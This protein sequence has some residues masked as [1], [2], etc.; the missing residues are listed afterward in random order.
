MIPVEGIKSF[1]VQTAY[2]LRQKER[3]TLLDTMLELGGPALVNKKL[4]QVIRAGLKHKSFY[5]NRRLVLG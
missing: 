5:R 1:A 2:R 4:E 3:C